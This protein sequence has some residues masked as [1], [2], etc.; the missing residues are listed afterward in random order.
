[1]P[2]DRVEKPVTITGRIY[3]YPGVDPAALMAKTR[4]I[5]GHD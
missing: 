3:G 2:G 4:Q 5:T 1:M